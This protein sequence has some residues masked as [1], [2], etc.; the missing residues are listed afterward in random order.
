MSGDP[1]YSSYAW[2]TLRSSIVRQWKAKN[3]PC[4]YCLQPFKQG[5]WYFVDH[6]KNRKQHPELALTPENLCC[7]HRDCNTK[8]AAFF[9]NNARE[10]IGVDGFPASWRDGS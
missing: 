1:F 9:E 7:M 6:I 4:A 3:R 8:K 5:D 2:K 10:Q